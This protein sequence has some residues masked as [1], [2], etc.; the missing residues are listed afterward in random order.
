MS[1]NLKRNTPDFSKYDAM[2]IG[3]LEDILRADAQ[4]PERDD[5]DVD[6]ILYIMEVLVQK[7]KQNGIAG[8]TALEAYQE[9]QQHYLPVVEEDIDIDS[10][11]MQKSKI[12]PFRYIATIAASLVLVFTLA[13]S[14]NAFSLKDV[15]DYVVRWAEGTFSFSVCA[16]ASEPLSDFGIV[17]ESIQS[18]LVEAEMNTELVPTWFPEEYKLSDIRFEETPVQ[19]TIVALL[20]CNE[21]NLKISIRTYLNEEAEQLEINEELLEVYTV[22][23]IDFYIVQNGELLKAAWLAEKYECYIAGLLT[24]EEMKAMIDS[25]GKG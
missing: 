16:A 23:E 5:S 24:L 6:E 1:D 11:P 18:A 17:Y 21:S 22:N 14:A 10:V 3:E 25:I 7:R 12:I 13:T 9:F 2:S 15:W 8:K 20:L 4:G 19:K